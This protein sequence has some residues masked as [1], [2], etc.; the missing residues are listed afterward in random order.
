MSELITIRERIAHARSYFSE[1]YGVVLTTFNLDPNFLELN[2]L[3]T[4][5]GFEDEDRSVREAELH[6]YLGETPCTVFYDPSTKPKIGGGYRYVAQ[7]VPVR[8]NFFHPK[9]VILAG[10]GG[11][12]EKGA[13]PNYDIDWVYLAVSSANLTQSG[14]GRNVESF[15]ETWIHTR[16]Q[17]S[18]RDL[19]TFLKW[20]TTHGSLK[21]NQNNSDAVSKVLNT[22]KNMKDR[23]RFGEDK[24]EPWSGT[25]YAD[26]YSSVV[27]KKG[28][29][30]FIHDHC[31]RRPSCIWVYSPY[32]GDISNQIQSFNAMETN[33]VPALRNKDQEISITQ[34]QSKELALPHVNVIKNEKDDGKR[35]WHMKAYWI[36]TEKKYFSA[37]GSCNFT[38][39][40]LSGKSSKNGNVE[41]MLVFNTDKKNDCF[42]GGDKVEPEEFAAEPE[43]EEEI[44]N[45]APVAIIVAWDW[46]NNVWRWNLN[47]DDDKREFMLLLPTYVKSFR[48]KSGADSKKGEPPE[49]GATFTLYYRNLAGSRKWLE[50]NGSIVEFNLKFSTRTYGEPLSVTQILDSWR[51]GLPVDRNKIREISEIDNDNESTGNKVDTPA[52]FDAVNLFDFYR[53]VRDLKVELS[54]EEMSE[55][56]K[57]SYLVGQSNSV[58]ALANLANQGSNLPAVRYLVLFEL[59]N[60]ISKH[61][62]LLG[63]VQVKNVARMLDKV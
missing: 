50:W 9:L 12:K 24:N 61:K 16:Q 58:M 54:N 28:F 29:P 21:V 53:A 18:C 47:D 51:K 3:P 44:P 2:V 59:N 20:V 41:A 57:M 40:G 5:F 26:F 36:E 46:E 52:P 13:N 32:W 19:Q 27:H 4:I 55:N 42:P 17:P 25:L 31:A 7:P 6:K 11:Y 35:F 43:P 23:R 15:G 38:N 34:D 60:I 10:R 33:L 45:V 49:P 14:W 56:R 8:G 48:I 22:L 39:A 37:V 1:L 30:T 62:K 63:D